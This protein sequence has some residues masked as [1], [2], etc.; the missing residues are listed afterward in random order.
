MA[1]KTFV[2]DVKEILALSQLQTSPLCTKGQGTFYFGMFKLV[3]T[4]QFIIAFQCRF[5]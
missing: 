4:S 1:I 5:V 3:N 2:L